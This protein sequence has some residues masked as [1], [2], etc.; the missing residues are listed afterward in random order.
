MNVT[1]IGT[2]GKPTLRTLTFRN[3]G[4][5]E[6]NMA[7]KIEH[8]SVVSV[9]YTGTFDDG[10]IFDSSEGKDPLTFLVGHGQMITGFEQEML[11]AEV[12]EKRQLSL[13]HI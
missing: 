1:T 6:L 12:G 7:S 3:E 8:N 13:I 10:K 5:R 11:G 9:H 2:T 4:L